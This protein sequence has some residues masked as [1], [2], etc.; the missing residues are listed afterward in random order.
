MRFRTRI[1]QVSAVV[2][3]LALLLVAAT[4]TE[5]V[6]PQGEPFER[7]WARTDKPVADLR[8]SRT[9]MWG[10]E[11]NTNAMREPYVE[12]HDNS[13][14]VQYFDKS[15]MEVTT[16]PSVPYDSIWF[17]TNGL[18]VNELMTGQMQV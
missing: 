9:W 10:P 17:V 1:M 2:A 16:D 18:L 4:R 7:T 15:R 12:G 3:A 6:A 14:E 8:V 13:R 11:A 5:A